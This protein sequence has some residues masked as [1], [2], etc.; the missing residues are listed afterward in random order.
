MQ[1]K[2]GNI[3]STSFNVSNGVRQGGILSPALFN[4]YMDDL[5]RQLG[6]CKTGCMVGDM[7]INHFL[8]ADDVTILYP[9]SSGFQQLLNICTDYGVEFD[10]KYNAKKSVV[11]VCRTKDVLK[12]KFSPFYLYGVELGVANATKYLGHILTDTLEDDADI[13]PSKYVG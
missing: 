2:W 11:M 4:A 9:S 1:V 10:I 3:L 13:C 7:L 6:A 5:S 8:Y 12:I